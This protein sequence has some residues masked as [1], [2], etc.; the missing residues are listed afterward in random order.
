MSEIKHK[1]QT[2]LNDIQSHASYSQL[3]YVQCLKKM[4]E[5]NGVCIG[6]LTT[7]LTT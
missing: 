3:F 7:R 2:T 1:R 6:V 4:F 5:E